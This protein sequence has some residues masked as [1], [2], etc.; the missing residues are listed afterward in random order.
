MVVSPSSSREQQQQSCRVHIVSQA[1]GAL[2]PD[3]NDEPLS[4]PSQVESAAKRRECAA[5]MQ[6]LEH[7][8]PTQDVHLDDDDD[9]CSE[10]E[11]LTPQCSSERVFCDEVEM[12]RHGW[13]DKQGHHWNET[14]M[15]KDEVQLLCDGVVSSDC[16]HQIRSAPLLD[17]LPSPTVSDSRPRVRFADQLQH[18]QPLSKNLS[19]TDGSEQLSS[20]IRAIR[21]DAHQMQ[22][23]TV[24]IE[25][26]GTLTKLGSGQE[27]RVYQLVLGSRRIF[28]ERGAD[29]HL[30]LHTEDNIH[31][32]HASI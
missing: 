22:N 9:L 4:W 11:V 16:Q 21:S 25:G 24:A 20:K 27:H 31:R 19:K 29:A 14:S 3:D 28:L 5:C 2:V 18:L 10:C 1:Q 23:E 6:Q 13:C 8:T 26:G 17:C 32:H 7:Q 30:V 15:P 12:M